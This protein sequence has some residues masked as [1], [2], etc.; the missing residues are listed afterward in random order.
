[1][2]KLHDHFNLSFNGL[3][4]L[5]PPLLS[6]KRQSDNKDL[7]STFMKGLLEIRMSLTPVMIACCDRP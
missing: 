5:Q 6:K 7:S 3:K 1:M 4:M 2:S